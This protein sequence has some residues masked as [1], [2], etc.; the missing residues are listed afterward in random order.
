MSVC[1]VAISPSLPPATFTLPQSRKTGFSKG[2]SGW[3]VSHCRT[4]LQGKDHVT[5]LLHTSVHALSL[6]LLLNTSWCQGKMMVHQAAHD[7]AGF[8]RS[9]LEGREE[10]SVGE[11]TSHASRCSSGPSRRLLSVYVGMV[12]MV[13]AYQV[14]S[15]NQRGC[16]HNSR[17]L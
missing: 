3:A 11:N 16:C 5:H 17:G 8:S 9:A 12:A 6:S 1:A 4:R 2:W 10:R 14:H 13:T 15:N 7:T